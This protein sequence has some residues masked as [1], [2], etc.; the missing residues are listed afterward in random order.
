MA[1]KKGMYHT[2]GPEPVPAR[3]PQADEPITDGILRPG[4]FYTLAKKGGLYRSEEWVRDPQGNL[5][6][7]SHSEWDDF[8][9]AFTRAGLALKASKP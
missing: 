1:I 3:L 5:T 6:L 8:V 7:S 9:Y 4:K 2:K